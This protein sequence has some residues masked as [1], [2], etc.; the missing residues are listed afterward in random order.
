[1]RRKLSLLSITVSLLFIVCNKTPEIIEIQN[2][3]IKCKI[4]G[5]PAPSWICKTPVKGGYYTAVGFAKKSTWGFGFMRNNAILDANIQIAR[6]INVQIKNYITSYF[7]EIGNKSIGDKVIEQFTKQIVYTTTLKNSKIEDMWFDPT[8]N[9]YVFV[10]VPKQ[11]NLNQ[12]KQKIISSF[13]N[14]EALWQQ[15]KSE[16]AEKKLEKEIEI[17]KGGK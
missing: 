9:M 15:F 7:S 2:G 1:M 17:I 10:T 3:K 16:E 13:N 8:G 14:K 12:I 5:K 6:Q 11:Q 4:Q